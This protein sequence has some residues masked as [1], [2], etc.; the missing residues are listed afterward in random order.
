MKRSLKNLFTLTT[1]LLFALPL[2]AQNEILTG[3]IL[4]PVEKLQPQNSYRVLIE[5]TIGH[6]WHINS[7]RPLE[8]F[9]IPTEITAKGDTGITF[10]KVEYPRPELKKFSFSDTRMAVYE[11][12]VYALTTLTV[13]PGIQSDSVNLNANIY[14][15][16][17]NDQSCLAPNEI[18]VQKKAALAQAGETVIETNKEIFDSV[19]PQFQSAE[20]PEKEKSLGEVVTEEGMVYAFIFIFLGGLAL[21]LTPC[22]YPLIPITISYFGGQAEGTRGGLVLRAI[23]YV[24]GMSVTYSI[25]GVAAALTGG[26]LGAAL[27]NPLVL[28]FI[29]LVLVVL[30]LSMF[31]LYEIRVPQSLALI[32]GKS[33]SGYFGTL[34]MGLTVGLIAAP[35]IGPFVLGL[36][37]YVG[38]IGDPVLGFWMFFVLAMG[39][40]TPF[41]FL[42]IFSGAMNK[43]PRSGAWMVWVRNLFGFILIGM[44]VYF[45]E[46]LFGNETVYFVLLGLVSVTGGV[47]MCWLDKNAGQKGFMIARNVVGVALIAL[48][49]FLA[50]PA[51]SEAGEGI[52]WQPYSEQA[53]Q[54]ATAQ[55]KPV[56][57]DFYADWC[58][59]CK[60]LDKF[61][62]TDAQVIERAKNFV[63]LKADLTTFDSD[64]T[65]LLREKYNIKGVPT[66]VFLAPDGNE[67]ES[68]RLAGFEAADQFL[69]RMQQTLAV[70]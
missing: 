51:E 2:S 13:Q 14:Y 63:T 1:V 26:I 70:K 55:G 12:T 56:M 45:L 4:L 35:C 52:P 54:Q 49:I 11:G 37:T 5:M 46:P 40:G 68:L 58:L 18:D 67:L 50:W 32:G 15:Q 28:I 6:G 27:Q 33:R 16:A 48:G 43:L 3:R 31:G 62:F 10:G 53:L 8:D 59:P 30:A 21:N 7:N 65:Q 19:L 24:L 44:A 41:L 39:L 9:L 38:D 20:M 60:E 34:F 69:E 36:L 23:V 66:I 47:Y 17:C 29:A 25:L 57:I 42:G 61:T 22:V 64:V